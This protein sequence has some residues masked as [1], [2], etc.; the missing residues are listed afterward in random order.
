MR[1]TARSIAAGLAL[2]GLLVAPIQAS[3]VTYE[4]SFSD[5][6]YPKTFDLVVMRPVSFVT[7]VFGT[8]LF[9]PLGALGAATVTED[10]PTVY[11][12]LVGAPARFTFKRRL[13][14]CRSVDLAL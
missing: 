10:F 7:L 14:E 4:D 11:D 6:N 12:N 9:I 1:T 3:A 13:G 5:C 2:A 8:V